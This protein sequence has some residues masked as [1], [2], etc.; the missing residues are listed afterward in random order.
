MRRLFPVFLLAIALSAPALADNIYVGTI[1]SSGSSTTNLTTGT[2][3]QLYAKT[4]Y[5]LQCDGA[6]YEQEAPASAPPTVTSSNGLLLAQY[7]IFDVDTTSAK[8]AQDAFWAIGIL[9]VTGT[10]SCKVFVSSP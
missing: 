10:V 1:T 2:P 5:V 8:Y 3:F 9:P 4:H 7:A 6:A